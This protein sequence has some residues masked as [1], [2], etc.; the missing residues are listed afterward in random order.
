[1]ARLLGKHAPDP[2]A[3]L[4]TSFPRPVAHMISGYQWYS[5]P[6]KKPQV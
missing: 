4:T 6:K 2:M 5:Q 1:M 3:L